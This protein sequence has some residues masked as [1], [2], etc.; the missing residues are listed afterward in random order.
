MKIN[1]ITNLKSNTYV[2]QILTLMSGTLLAQ[3]IMLGA[4]PILT[5]LYTPTEFGLF[6]LFLSII[7]IIGSI[8]SLKYDQAIMLPKSEK[9]AQALVFLS[10]LITVSITIISIVFILL[11]ND[12]ILDYFDG[13]ITILYLIPIGILLT[14]LVQIFTAYSSRNQFYK[15][16]SKTKVANA[17]FL[18]SVQIGLKYLFN[19]NALIEGKLVAD[20]ISLLLLFRYHFK[21]QT[22]QIKFL[23]KRRIKLNVD[24]HHHFPKYQAGTVF[25]NSLSQNIPILLLGTLYS[26][27]IAGYYALTIRVLQAPVSLIG[28]STRE[29]FYQKASRLYANKESFLKLYEKTTLGLLKIIIVPTFIIYL[30]GEELYSILFGTEWN[31]AGIYSETLIFWILLAFIN[32][33]SIMAYSI[34]NL[35]KVQMYLEFFSVI[36]RFSSIYIGFY[37]FNS[38]YMSILLFTGTSIFV[39]LLLISYIY[40]IIRKKENLSWD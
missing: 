11:F 31:I 10:I 26:S 1:K 17:S 28:M 24:R 32:S 18:A 35:Q 21:K 6:S 9:N 2:M 29:V 22:L 12:F 19:Y 37:Y 8:S 7:T 15:H 39:N 14:G 20:L 13:S 5:R 34:L 3:I 36:L 23:S 27:E 4:I 16:L 38:G 33:P 30:F 25:L 40:K